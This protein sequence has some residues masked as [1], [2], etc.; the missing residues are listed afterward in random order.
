MTI[1]QKMWTFYKRPIFERVR[2]FFVQTLHFNCF[3][4]LVDEYQQ[5]QDA[6]ADDEDDEDEDD[7]GQEEEDY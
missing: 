3:T 4:D 5:Y 6:T 2:I 1:R 7:Y